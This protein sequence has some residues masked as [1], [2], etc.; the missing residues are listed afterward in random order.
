MMKELGGEK[1]QQPGSFCPQVCIGG[2]QASHL[3]LGFDENGITQT[4][5][6]SLLV[7]FCQ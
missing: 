7:P 6:A 1:Q 3:S 5:V 2:N 4:F